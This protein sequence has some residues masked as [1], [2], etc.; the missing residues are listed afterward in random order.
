MREKIA[1]VACMYVLTD[2][3]TSETGRVNLKTAVNPEEK[4]NPHC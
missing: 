2:G 1:Y 4:E 3:Q